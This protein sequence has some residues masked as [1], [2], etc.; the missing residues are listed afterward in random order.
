MDEKI[1]TNIEEAKKELD[2]L[3]ATGR[4][5]NRI[6]WIVIHSSMAVMI[7]VYS[8]SVST[9][10]WGVF[11]LI[12]LFVGLAIYKIVTKGS[13]EHVTRFDVKGAIRKD[14]IRFLEGYI[15]AKEKEQNI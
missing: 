1:P 3:I 7:L 13:H 8:I 6:G 2:H 14:R 5:D 11:S 12:A 15:A 4:K 9:Y 10:N